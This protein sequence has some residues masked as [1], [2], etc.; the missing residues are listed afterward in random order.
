MHVKIPRSLEKG[1]GQ[2]Q[3]PGLSDF[4]KNQESV[5]SL[6]L[7]LHGFCP[8]LCTKRTASKLDKDAFRQAVFC[9]E[10]F[11]APK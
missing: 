3:L 9:H 5:F 7:S 4:I 6:C 1:Q 8:G 2:Q 11:N 10:L